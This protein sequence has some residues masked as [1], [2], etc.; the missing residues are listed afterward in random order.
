MLK[1]LKS[2]GSGDAS[3]SNMVN[4]PKHSSNLHKSTFIIFINHCEGNWVGKTLS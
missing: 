2:P 1:C 4:D 3:T